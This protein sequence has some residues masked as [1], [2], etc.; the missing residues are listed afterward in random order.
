MREFKEIAIIGVGLI[1]G[2]LAAAFRKRA[3]CEKIIGIDVNKEHLIKAEKMNIID[4]GYLEIGDNLK[5]SDLIIIAAP[6]AKILTILDELKGEGQKKQIIIDVGSTKKEIVK[7]AE[8]IFSQKNKKVFIGAHPMAGS[9]KSGVEFADPD[10]FQNAPF[11]LTPDSKTD[12]DSVD[13]VKKVL[14]KLGSRIYIITAEEHDRCAALLSHLPHLLSA[15]LLNTVS[16][17]RENEKLNKLA[18]SGFHDMT[19]IAGGSPQLWQDIFWT[20][21]D[22]LKNVLEKYISELEKIKESLNSEDKDGLYYLLKEAADNK[23]HIRKE[24]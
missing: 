24:E 22:N 23:N 2:S 3:I 4:K 6:V 16:R 14:N 20:N 17:D 7:K 11:I 15:V 5:N 1:G 13:R 21:K 18:G 12:R 9:E 8:K 10:L 19:R